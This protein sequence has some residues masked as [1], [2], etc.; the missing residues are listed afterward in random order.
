M[1]NNKNTRKR[2]EKKRKRK[3]KTRWSILKSKW[4]IK[5]LKSFPKF[6]SYNNKKEAYKAIRK[7]DGNNCWL[8]G[9]WVPG[10]ETILD[11]NDYSQSLD[12]VI[13]AAKGG[14][15]CLANLKLAH[16]KCNSER[17]K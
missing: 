14:C 16:R 4:K 8:C 5:G 7:R 1:S 10:P 3:L 9:T 15:D 17:H 12:H 6:V 13:P 11:D 2:I